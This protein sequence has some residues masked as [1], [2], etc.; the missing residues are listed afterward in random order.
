MARD[1]QGNIIPNAPV[2]GWSVVGQIP[3]VGLDGA[4][5]PV[6][7]MRIDFRTGKGV[8]SSIFVPQADYN[9]V[10]VKARIAA[11]A[12]MIDQVHALTG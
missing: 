1:A 2:T 3:T 8:Q 6:E 7:G 11:A 5:R 9:P 12:A 10:N 4:N